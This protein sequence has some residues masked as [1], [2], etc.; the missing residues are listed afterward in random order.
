V[1]PSAP[2]LSA[3]RVFLTD[4]SAI[5]PAETVMEMVKYYRLAEI[6]GGPTA[7]TNGNINCIYLPAGLSMAKT[8]S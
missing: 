1:P 4:A 5:S 6:V 7:G 3:R 8:D 2:N